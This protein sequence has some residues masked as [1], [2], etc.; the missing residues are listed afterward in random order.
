MFPGSVVIAISRERVTL[1]P[2]QRKSPE[3]IS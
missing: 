2:E 1:L 3:I